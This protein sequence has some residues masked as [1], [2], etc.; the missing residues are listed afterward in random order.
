MADE[1]ERVALPGKLD[2]LNVDLRHQRA[3]GVNHP[4]VAGLAALAHRGRYAV[5]RINDTLAIGNVV[6][7]MDKDR[8]LLCQLV[9]NVAVTHNLPP[10]IDGRAEGFERD[11]KS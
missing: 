2:G 4:E 3:S 5:G 10:Y 8:A 11:R 1:H 9:H 7:L 6:D